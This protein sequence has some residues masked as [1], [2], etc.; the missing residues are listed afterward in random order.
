[1]CLR[2]KVIEKGGLDISHTTCPVGCPGPLS[3]GT[4]G[5]PTSSTLAEPSFANLRFPQQST[6]LNPYSVTLHLLADRLPSKRSTFGAIVM[7]A[8]E[9]RVFYSPGLNGDSKVLFK[10]IQKNGIFFVIPLVFRVSSQPG[11]TDSS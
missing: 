2:H 3:M 9:V 8:I 7:K 4:M 6:F 11:V 10:D 5:D 1:M